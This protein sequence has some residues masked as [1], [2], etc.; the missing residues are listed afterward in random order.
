MPEIHRDE[1]EIWRLNDKYCARGIRLLPNDMVFGGF[2]GRSSEPIETRI[3]F[4]PEENF[5]CYL[6]IYINLLRGWRSIFSFKT[7]QGFGL[8]RYEFPW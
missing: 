6:R 3:D 4:W 7:V 5:L 2:P 1:D 8:R